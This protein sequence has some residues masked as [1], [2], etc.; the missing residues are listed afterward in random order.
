MRRFRQMFIGMAMCLVILAGMVLCVVSE[1]E[2]ITYYVTK[3]SDMPMPDYKL[4][5]QVS[6][7]T[8]SRQVYLFGG[9]NGNS[10]GAWT[11]AIR[12]Y[13]ISTNTWQILPITLP[14]AYFDSG[15]YGVAQA[16][17]GKFDALANSLRLFYAATVIKLAFW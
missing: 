16:S 9:Y 2:A 7:V 3:K 10:N 13:D 5:Y 6:D 12:R 1:T 15:Y 14:Y 11:N 8:S 4:G 17:N